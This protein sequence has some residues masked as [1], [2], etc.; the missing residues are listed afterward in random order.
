M[1]PLSR[2]ILIQIPGWLFMLCLLWWAVHSN[3]LQLATAVW[4]MVAWMLKD[5]ALYPLCKAGFEN[6]SAIGPR[7]LIGRHAEALTPLDPH[8]QIRVN[9]ERWSAHCHNRGMLAAG[10]R[11]R[12]I[13]ADGL[14]LI[15]EPVHP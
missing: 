2:Y 10:S 12:I 7:A 15:V 9:G 3:W 5:A 1:S 11:V 4:I 8:G 13:D 6:R 14:I